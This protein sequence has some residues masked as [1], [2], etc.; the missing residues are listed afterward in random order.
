[1][2]DPGAFTVAFWNVENLFDADDDP[3]NPGDDEYLP[4]GGWTEARYQTKLD[5]LAE[6]IAAVAPSVLGM[7][8]VENR[9]VLADLFA[10]PR[11]ASLEYEVAHVE[12][13]DKR[14]IDVALAFRAPFRLAPGQSVRLVPIEKEGELPT[15]GV[16]VVELVTA[17]SASGLD[18]TP[19]AVL[20]N[21][22]PSRGGDRDGAF[23]AVAG[24]VVRGIVDALGHDRDLVVMGDLNDDPF[25]ASVRQHLGAIRSRNAVANRNDRRALFNPTWALLGTP[26]LGTLYYNSDWVWNAFDQI[27]VSRGML[28]PAGF[29][30]VDGSIDVYAPDELRD[31]YRRPRRFRKGRG[32]EW[33]EGYSDH[34]MVLGR[35]R[36][37]GAV[38]PEQ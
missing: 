36:A 26:D 29:A 25:D 13:P 6:V 28:D 23:R 14:G 22:W 18:G 19:L 8:E 35:I 12:S 11:L 17:G 15:R 37:A 2:V 16:L 3:A 21:H 7:A 5:R 38:A 1:L 32:D 34:F 31:Q 10:H 9:R 20:V 24:T 30:W 27:L 33:N 4:D